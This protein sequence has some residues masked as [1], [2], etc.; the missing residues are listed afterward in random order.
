MTHEEGTRGWAIR[1][2]VSLLL[3]TAALAAKLWYPQGADAV[4]AWMAG[5]EGN[6]VQEAFAALED[7]IGDGDSASRA[8]QA[9][10]T[11]IRDN[12]IS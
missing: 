6:C 10:C 12:G 11:E 4:E 9:F 8:V 2:V 3:L 5:Q 1:I 7:S